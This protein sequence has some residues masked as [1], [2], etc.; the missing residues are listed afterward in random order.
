MQIVDRIAGRMFLEF[1]T[2]FSCVQ[3]I[4]VLIVSDTQ[5]AKV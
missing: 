3:H 1:S 2:R 4:R 5:A